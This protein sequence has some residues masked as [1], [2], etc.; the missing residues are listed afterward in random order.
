MTAA[1]RRRIIRIACLFSAL[2]FLSSPACRSRDAPDKKSDAQAAPDEG[3]SPT[4]K[5]VSVEHKVLVDL[6]CDVRTPSKLWGGTCRRTVSTPLVIEVTEDLGSDIMSWTRKTTVVYDPEDLSIPLKA[7]F[8]A[9]G[10]RGIPPF[11]ALVTFSGTKD[12]RTAAIV[13]VRGKAQSTI[14]DRKKVPGGTVLVPISLFFLGPRLLDGEG[15]LANVT[16]LSFSHSPVSELDCGAALEEG[17]KLVREAPAEDG[18]HAFKL[19]YRGGSLIET[20]RFGK[21]GAWL[22]D[23]KADSG[24]TMTVSHDP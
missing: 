4:G 24:V 8:E 14:T 12:D 18:S 17:A 7:S 5:P 21:D 19:Y 16:L 6:K 13:T 11:K 10:G 1:P 20:I 3:K 9:T 22:D 15:E 23:E 2:C